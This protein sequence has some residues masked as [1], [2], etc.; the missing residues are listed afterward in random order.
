MRLAALLLSLVCVSALGAQ[1]SWTYGAGDHFE[2]YTTGGDDVARRALESFDRVHTY[3]ERLLQ[4][5]PVGG[6]RTRLIVFSNRR[7]FEP[8]AANAS[9][10]AFYQSGVDNDVIV[11]PAFGPDAFPAVV[12]EYTHLVLRRVGAR[13]PLWLEDGLAEYLSTVTPVNG[14]LQVGTA[15]RDRERALGFGVRLMPLERLFA[16]GRDSAEHTSASRTGLFYAQSWALTHM[17]LTDDRYRSQAPALL[18]KLAQGSPTALVLTT[19]YQKPVDEIARDLTRYCLRGG[20]R[21]SFVDAPAAAARA[22]VTTRAATS[23]EAQVALAAM[24]GANVQRRAE[25]QAAFDALE[26]ENPHDLFFNESAALFAIRAGRID[27][28]RPYLERA[29]ELG[30]LNARIHS[31]LATVR[32]ATE[33]DATFADDAEDALLARALILASDD[34]E[35]RMQAARSFV[36]RRRG[37]EAWDLLSPIT[38]VPTEYQAMF[39]EALNSARLHSRERVIDA[40]LTN[41]ACDGATRVLEVE[42]GAGPKRLIEGPATAAADLAVTLPCGTQDNRALRVGYEERPDAE[43]R[44]DGTVMFVTIR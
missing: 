34:V 41:V 12:H 28:A 37:G 31:H 9:V 44:L 15:P 32:A 14:R 20:Y 42:T 22:D 23:F 18:A 4:V 10:K 36:R 29:A 3:F 39:A 33:T 38:R 25:A 2:V 30:S 1:A 19:V 11:L 5:P 21:S 16:I 27:D 6:A 40:R 26:R 13:Y 24:L 35:V 17:L 7:E 8:Y 43:R